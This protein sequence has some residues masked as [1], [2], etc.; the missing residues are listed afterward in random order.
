VTAGLSA[1][2][3]CKAPRNGRFGALVFRACGL[4]QS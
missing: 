1:S 3:R 2:K 4:I